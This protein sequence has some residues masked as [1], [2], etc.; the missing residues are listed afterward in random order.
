VGEA[1]AELARQ[2][3]QSGAQP[4]CRPPLLY[5]HSTF[6]K[7]NKRVQVFFPLRG[8]YVSKQTEKTGH[9]SSVCFF[10]SDLKQHLSFQI[11]EKNQRNVNILI[12]YKH[13]L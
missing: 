8:K 2:W 1:E 5:Q 6:L 10:Y 4:L 11:L 9:S 12:V 3:D 13:I 7:L